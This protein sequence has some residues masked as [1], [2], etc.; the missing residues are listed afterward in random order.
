[1]LIISVSSLRWHGKRRQQVWARNGTG[2]FGNIIANIAATV[3]ASSDVVSSSEAK[4][5]LELEHRT[6]PHC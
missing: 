2:H 5:L 3:D 6:S 1:M 4:G